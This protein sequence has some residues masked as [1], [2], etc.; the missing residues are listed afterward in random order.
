MARKCRNPPEIALNAEINT[1]LEPLPGY[2]SEEITVFTYHCREE[3]FI[4]DIM[5][6][7]FSNDILTL[8]GFEISENS[9]VI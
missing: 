9:I 7:Q 5:A 3:D 1:I 2:F 8:Q 6:I 4:E